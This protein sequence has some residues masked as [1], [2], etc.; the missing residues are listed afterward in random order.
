MPNPVR[1]PVAAITRTVEISASY[2]LSVEIKKVC[3]AL[4]YSEKRSVDLPYNFDESV[5]DTAKDAL[6]NTV[7]TEVERQLN[8]IVESQRR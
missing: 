7:I 6:W 5:L 4:E 8:N 3:H 2:K 1:K